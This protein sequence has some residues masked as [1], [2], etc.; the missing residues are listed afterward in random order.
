LNYP[1]TDIIEWDVY[2]W[3]KALEV[4]QPIIDQLPKDAKILA[5]GERKGGLSLWLALQGFNVVCTD[6]AAIAST[7]QSL[8]HSYNVQNKITYHEVDIVNDKL[9]A[10]AYDL[11]IMK[12]VLGGLKEAY[13]DA[14][15]RTSQARQHAIDNIYTCLKPGGY[16]LS[17]DNMQGSSLHQYLRNRKNKDKNWY[18]FSPSEVQDLFKPFSPIQTVFFGIIPTHFKNPTLNKFIYFINQNLLQGLPERAKY[19][20]ITTARK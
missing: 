1:I 17:A 4:W 2:N 5:V 19:I 16:L 10:E 13:Q 7:A 14:R 11:V 8:H 12:S 9:P 15:T 18:Y 3:S 20:G 6:R